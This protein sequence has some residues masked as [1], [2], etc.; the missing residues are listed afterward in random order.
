MLESVCFTH[1]GT[2]A[3]TPENQVELKMCDDL[4]EGYKM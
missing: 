4:I 3:S 1:V 2:Y